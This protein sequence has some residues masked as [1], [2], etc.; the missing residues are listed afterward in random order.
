MTRNKFDE[1]KYAIFLVLEHPGRYLSPRDIS[2]KSGLTLACVKS[3]LTRLT[4]W[5]YI[6]RARNRGSGRH[7][8]VY[9]ALK[10][11]GKRMLEKWKKLKAQEAET[12]V[13][14]SLKTRAGK[15]SVVSPDH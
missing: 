3:E 7:W 14:V 9:R 15:K 12:G 2:R 11:K 5:H 8:Y 10:Q 1:S 13:P 4:E 6:W